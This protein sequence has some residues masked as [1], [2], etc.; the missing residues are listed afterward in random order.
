MQAIPSL[1]AGRELLACAPTGSGKTAAFVIPMLQQL[2]ASGSRKRP[3][4][5]PR[6][7]LVAPTQE[8]A[9]QTHREVLKLAQGGKLSA[10]LL[11]RKMVTSAL[12]EQRGAS[13]AGGGA[14]SLTRFDIIVSTPLR[15]VG[16]VK[17]GLLPLG[18]VTML[19]LDEADKLLELVSTY[20]YI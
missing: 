16:L 9:R 5:G 13:G 12:A 11:T 7:V 8:L 6:A 18:N 19:V 4:A 14:A 17:K 15:L 2:A 20:V 1:L 10:A 3:G